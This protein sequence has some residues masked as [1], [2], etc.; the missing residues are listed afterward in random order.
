MPSHTS[1]SMF[2]GVKSIE[3]FVELSFPVRGRSLPADHGYGLYASLVHLFPT[4]RE[5]SELSI[6]TIPG[7]PDRQGKIILTDESHL[8]IRVPVSKI[9][10]AYP[11]A[12]K[13]IK[14]GSHEVQIG[15]PAVSVLRPVPTLRARIVTLK[16]YMEADFFLA[17]V[18]RQLDEL[19][20]AGELSIP[21]NRDGT[22]SR[23]TI[24]IKRNTVIGF[25]TE[26]TGLNDED[27]VKLQQYG[28]GGKRRMGCGVFVPR[29]NL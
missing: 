2:Q 11:L 29:F 3:P 24:K 1:F 17:A 10:Q 22:L 5:Q 26:V 4:L 27:S 25:T 13:K 20:I 18:R 28:L 16:G 9:P 6:L 7:I 14:I 8:R 19:G 12:G 15:I 21:L 23:K